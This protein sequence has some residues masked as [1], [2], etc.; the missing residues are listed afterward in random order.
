MSAYVDQLARHERRNREGDLW[1]HMMADSGSELRSF[2]ARIG[3]RPCWR[4]G[5]HYDLTP[6]QRAAAVAAGA[7][8]VT[9]RDLVRLRRS[10]SPRRRP[11]SVIGR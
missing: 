6:T 3:V 8:E 4:D 5:D 10:R 7:V 9:S 1:C 2:A 11:N